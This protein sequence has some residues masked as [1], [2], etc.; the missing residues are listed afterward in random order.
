MSKYL[1]SVQKFIPAPAQELF[2]IV[3]DPR[4]HPRIDGSGTVR[5]VD[6]DGPQTLT[7]GSTFTA[8]MKIGKTYRM[9]NTV[10]EYEAGRVIA[11]K[12]SGDYVWR[13]TFEPLDGGTLVTEQWDA[14]T[15][16]G[17]AV[18]GLLGFPGRNRRGITRT[19]DRLHQ[20]ALD[21]KI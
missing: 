4:Q 14:S 10:V 18:M 19:L 15:S 20:I 17:R 5:G 9:T 13:Y 16:K 8:D 7:L 21:P 6:E 1:V 12:P 11:W 2:D 3:A